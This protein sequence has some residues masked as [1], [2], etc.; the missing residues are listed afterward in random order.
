MTTSDRVGYDLHADTLI[1]VGGGVWDATFGWVLD[2]PD[3]VAV[4]IGGRSFTSERWFPRWLLTAGVEGLAVDGDV[5]VEPGVGVDHGF[6]V[7]RP[8]RTA[9]QMLLLEFALGQFLAD[10][11]SWVS[12]LAEIRG[13]A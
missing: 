8:S 3:V 12:Q 7:L 4:R 1:M 6:V 13:A 10:V 2:R 9:P 11:E 5:Q